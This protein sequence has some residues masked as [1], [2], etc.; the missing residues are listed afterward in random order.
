[1][2]DAS[3]PYTLHNDPANTLPRDGYR[4]L[5]LITSDLEYWA[6]RPASSEFPLRPAYAPSVLDLVSEVT[7]QVP[8]AW[9]WK[10]SALDDDHE[11]GPLLVDVS[12]TPE[13]MRH[14]VS[15]WMPAGGAIALDAQVSLTVLSDHFTSMVQLTLAD[16]STATHHLKPDHLTAWLGALSD[17]QRDVWLGPI[18]RLAWRVNWGP[19]HEWKQLER[20]PTPARSRQAPPLALQ[21]PELARLQVGM[22]EHFVLSLTHE[23]LAMPQ[24]AAHEVSDIRH[25]I[26]TLLSQL[27]RLNFCD[28]EVAG[29]FV[30]L[31]AGHLWLMS[32]AQAVD[33]YT[34]L[35]ESP[36]GRLHQLEALLLSQDAPHD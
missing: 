22:R 1:M 3:S 7:G 2:S 27:E 9:L 23:V 4:F 34:N 36:Q 14:A 5:L 11:Y 15:C 21:Q 8:H 10:R 13:L 26:E 16:R 30:R 19:A 28:E 24:H 6:Y 12:E 17:D 25:W 32:D 31:M 20:P 35:D 33:I 29:Q 18:S